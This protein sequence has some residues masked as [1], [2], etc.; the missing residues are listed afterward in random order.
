MK[1]NSARQ[2]L[3]GDEEC[4]DQSAGM[5]PLVVCCSGMAG[6][7]LE[8]SCSPHRED[9]GKVHLCQGGFNVEVE[10]EETTEMIKGLKTSLMQKELVVSAQEMIRRDLISLVLNIEQW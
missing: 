8:G 6:L 2:Q 3:C 4:G 1:Q 7:M 5:Q 10:T 9:P